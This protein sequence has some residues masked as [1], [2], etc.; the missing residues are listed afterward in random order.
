MS[1]CSKPSSN[2]VLLKVKANI[3]TQAYNGL[4]NNT[5][6]PSDF[7]SFHFLPFSLIL[8]ISTLQSSLLFLE[9]IHLGLFVF[10]L[11]FF[12]ILSSWVLRELN[13]LP[14]SRLYFGFRCLFSIRIIVSTHKKSWLYSLSSIFL[15][16][17][18]MFLFII[19]LHPSPFART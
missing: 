16:I 4:K 17:Y 8:L 10:D 12:E 11:P 5:S 15:I 14:S 6:C 2:S 7:I 9:Q 3:L 18:I 19:Q 1:L 13:S